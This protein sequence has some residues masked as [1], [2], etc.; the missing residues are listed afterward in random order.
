MPLYFHQVS[1]D[2]IP[3]GFVQVTLWIC[4]FALTNRDISIWSEAST[5][6]I[7]QDRGTKW[8]SSLFQFQGMVREWK[9][10]P[11]DSFKEAYFD[12]LLSH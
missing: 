6:Q 11:A 10:R 12:D 4:P 2:E 8:I 1:S 3:A 9:F 5:G 7:H